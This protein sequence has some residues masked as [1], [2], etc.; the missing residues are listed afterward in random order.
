MKKQNYIFLI[1]IIFFVISFQTPSNLIRLLNVKYENRMEEIYGYCYPQ[2]YGFIKEVKNKFNLE[3]ITT[4]NF[5]DFAQSDYFLN[6]PHNKHSQDYLVLIN[7]DSDKKKNFS[8]ES[9]N[10]KHK[11]KK[12]FLIKNDRNN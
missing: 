11:A 4:I 2:G 12:C 10:I 5:D 3:N 1:V 8:L 9:Y 6:N 7:F